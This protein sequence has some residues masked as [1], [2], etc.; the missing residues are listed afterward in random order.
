MILG[1]WNRIKPKKDKA[2][3]EEKKRIVIICR[4][5]MITVKPDWQA[6]KR[7]L[8][9]FIVCVFGWGWVRHA[10]GMTL[11]HNHDHCSFGQCY[12]LLMRCAFNWNSESLSGHWLIVGVSNKN[13]WLR[14]LI[15][16]NNYQ[17]P[18]EWLLSSVNYQETCQKDDSS[19]CTPHSVYSNCFHIISMKPI[20]SLYSVLFIA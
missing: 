15:Q 3:G 2:S 20:K 5:L 6:N 8:I 16:C 4:W 17:N 7:K 9:S 1:K 19:N 10:Y 18:S 11:I 12:T 13:D 14:T